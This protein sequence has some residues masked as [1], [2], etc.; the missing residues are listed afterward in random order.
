MP[1]TRS[2]SSR[3]VEQDEHGDRVGVEAATDSLETVVQL[4][5]LRRAPRAPPAR[6]C[7]PRA[8]CETIRK[9]PLTC[10]RAKPGRS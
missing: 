8:D 6:R 4:R 1:S 2:R 7:R 9:G 3:A 10:R 5:H